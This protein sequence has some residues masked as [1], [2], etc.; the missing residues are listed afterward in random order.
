M[1]DYRAIGIFKISDPEIL[2]EAGKVLEVRKE[3]K[4]AEAT[5][6]WDKARGLAL[7]SEILFGGMEFSLVLA[8]RC[9]KAEKVD[10]R[11]GDVDYAYFL[12]EESPYVLTRFH[13]GIDPKYCHYKKICKAFPVCMQIQYREE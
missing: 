6:D 1:V 2:A 3:M 8:V 5:R 13:C 11:I 7:R 10:T 12:E 4:E 9:G